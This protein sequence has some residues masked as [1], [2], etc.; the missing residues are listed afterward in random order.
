VQAA[1]IHL[2]ERPLGATKGAV[3]LA[4]AKPVKRFRVHSDARLEGSRSGMGRGIPL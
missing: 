4:A 1:R 2:G 3:R